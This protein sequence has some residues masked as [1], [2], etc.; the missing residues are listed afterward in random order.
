[1]KNLKLKY[2]F[3][4]NKK[5]NVFLKQDESRSKLYNL[6]Y[7]HMFTADLILIINCGIKSF[8]A[9]IIEY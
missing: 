1:M 8:T 3:F 4:L 9:I 7:K 6:C 5:I 2:G